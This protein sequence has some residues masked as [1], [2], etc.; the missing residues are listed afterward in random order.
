MVELRHLGAMALM[1]VVAAVV[2]T[3]GSAILNGLAEQECEETTSAIW[4]AQ[5]GLCGISTEAGE[6][7]N[8]ATDYATNVTI[9]GLEGME[10]LGDWLPL[11]ALVV[12]AAIVIG[13]IVGYL[14]RTA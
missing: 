11:I 10:T 12:A 8:N 6:P 13:I 14:G 3:V 7:T 9:E 2:I 5:E 4:T 1:L